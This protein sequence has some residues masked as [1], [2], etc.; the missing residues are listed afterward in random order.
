ME[1]KKKKRNALRQMLALLASLIVIFL[2]LIF[3]KDFF[4]NVTSYCC[5]SKTYWTEI[6]GSVLEQLFTHLIFCLGIMLQLFFIIVFIVLA[7]ILILSFIK[8]FK[9]AKNKPEN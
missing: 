6:R 7:Y 9:L 4:V 8:F 3:L 2:S 1:K 5:P